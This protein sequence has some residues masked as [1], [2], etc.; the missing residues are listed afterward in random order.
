L[1]DKHNFHR[2]TNTPLTGATLSGSAAGNYNLTSVA[3]TAADITG[4]E[5]TVLSIT[6]NSKTYDGNDTA[7][8]TGYVLGGVVLADV[9]NVTLVIGAANFDTKD[10]GT[11]KTVTLKSTARFFGDI[12]AA[13][14]VVEP[15]ALLVGSLRIGAA[16]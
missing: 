8:T 11:D 1:N 12:L 7:T 4:A 6:A 14:L 5:V 3:T 16:P 13:H 2:R 9:G 10:V 15:G